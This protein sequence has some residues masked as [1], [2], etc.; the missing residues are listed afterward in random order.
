MA[1]PGSDGPIPT[2]LWETIREGINDYKYIYQLKMRIRAGKAAGN[3]KALEI[4]TQLDQLKGS[5]G[6]GPSFQEGQFGDWSSD[7][8]DAIRRQIV[9]WELELH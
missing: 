6:R 1:Y 5:L 3:P 9:A 2:P 7:V 8:F 4:E